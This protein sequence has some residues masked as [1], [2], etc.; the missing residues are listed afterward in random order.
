MKVLRIKGNNVACITMDE[1]LDNYKASV[2]GYSGL[3][4]VTKGFKRLDHSEVLK[5]KSY[6]APA[7][8]RKLLDLTDV[9]GWHGACCDAIADGT[10]MQVACRDAAVQGWIDNSQNAEDIVTTFRTAVLHYQA[11]GNGIIAKLRDSFGKWKGVELLK[12]HEIDIKH[13][14]NSENF[15]R[16]YYVQRRGKQVNV[17]PYDDIIHLKKPTHKSD[18]W[19]LSS[20]PIA[21][22]VET[23][24]QIKMLD[25]NNF[26]NGLKIDYIVVVQ[27]G[28][29][30]STDDDSDSQGSSIYDKVK[31]VFE[32]GVEAEYAGSSVILESEDPGSEIKLIPLRQNPKDGEYLKLKD[33]IRNETCVYHR[34]PKRLVG[35]AISGQLGGDNNSDMTIF[36]NFSLKPI[37][38]K[39][40]TILSDNFRREFGFS[41]KARD[42]DFGTLTDVFK[43][44]DEKAFENIRKA[45]RG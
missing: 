2:P 42:W 43:S 27:G 18:V 34:M 41:V 40:A 9:D 22:G 6:L 21:Q 19:G 12:P 14:V 3:K 38:N 32:E 5:Y 17:F 16:P 15:L 30:S 29:L 10:V 11:C 20:M 4:L 44:S 26:K 13:F 23:L 31:E 28:S 33:D 45:N 24:K 39:F 35:Q 7:N 37:A 36:Y 25:Y 8:M 1:L